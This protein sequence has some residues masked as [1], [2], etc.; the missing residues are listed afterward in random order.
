[1]A[2]GPKPGNGGQPGARA[3]TSYDVARHAGVSQS[4]VSR[5]LTPGGSV[6][7]ATRLRVEAAIAALGY[8]PNAI[9]RSLITQRSNMVAIIV[10]NL[11]FHPEL[12]A[13]L[14]RGF[15]ARGLHVLL[16]TLDDEAEAD[17]IVD[18]IWQYRVDGVVAAVTLPTPHVALFATR[19]TPLVFINR[20]YD[21]ARVNSVACDQAGGERILVDRLL[22]TGHRRFGI[23]SGDPGSEVGRRRVEAATARLRDA[24]I[25]DIR[26]ASGD[27]DYAGGKRALHE[28][29]RGSGGV[30]DAVLCASDIMAIGCMD[31]ARFDLGLRVPADLSVVG[32]DGVAPASWASYDLVTVRQPL[33]AMVEAAVDMLLARA[34][35]PALGSEKRLFPGAL[36]VGSSARI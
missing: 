29:A 5:C 10:A 12:T 21:D 22:A 4:Q 25:A 9:A 8:R 23:V 19:G 14:S 31:A 7:P 3:V 36:V 15:A 34:A 27:F 30:P 32:F 17:Q 18:R 11:D 1:M 16:F 35:D 24:G 33:Q 20:L 2:T 13:R 6:A 28:F 26:L